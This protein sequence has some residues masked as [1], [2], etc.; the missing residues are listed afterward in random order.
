MITQKFTIRNKF[1]EVM[2][3]FMLMEQVNKKL[4]QADACT[5]IGNFQIQAQADACARML[6]N[7]AKKKRIPARGRYPQIIQESG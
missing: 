7:I 5:R 2:W 1:I 3:F 6:I 4:A